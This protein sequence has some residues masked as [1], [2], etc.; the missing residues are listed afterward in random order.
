MPNYIAQRLLIPNPEMAKHLFFNEVLY[1]LFEASYDIMNPESFVRYVIDQR[2]FRWKI[3][4]KLEKIKLFETQ[5]F[6]SNDGN[7]LNV[8]KYSENKTTLTAKDLVPAEST[9]KF[10]EEKIEGIH[11]FVEEC[12]QL[13]S[14]LYNKE[15]SVLPWKANEL[16]FL[17]RVATEARTLEI[18]LAKIKGDVQ[19]QFDFLKRRVPG[20]IATKCENSRSARR[21]KENKR[22]FG[23]RKNKRALSSSVK[24]MD[25]ILSDTER[26]NV[27]VKQVENADFSFTIKEEDVNM[28]GLS[29]LRQKFHKPGLTLLVAKHV[30]S[31][32]ALKLV[33]KVLDDFQENINGKRNQVR[34]KRKVTTGSQMS[35]HTALANTVKSNEQNSL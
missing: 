22:K 8:R 27:I 29:L 32:D 11:V 31:N 3:E 6:S 28:D 21:K 9:L 18:K 19:E 13:K 30:F 7:W 2:P 10:L 5:L 33:Q 4:C 25:A 23:K 14:K 34:K 15:N 17:E 1:E 20:G 16:L 24:V 12:I 26:K 35:L